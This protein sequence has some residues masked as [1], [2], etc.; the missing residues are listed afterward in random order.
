M[1]F[2]LGKTEKWVFRQSLYQKVRI[3]ADRVIL[4]NRRKKLT[5]EE[6][7]ANFWH[8]FTYPIADQWG[9]QVTITTHPCRQAL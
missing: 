1:T 8:E 2:L 5:Y 4:G 7:L 9:K 6:S 3:K